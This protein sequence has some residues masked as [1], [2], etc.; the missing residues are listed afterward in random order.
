MLSIIRVVQP[1]PLVPGR[2]LPT[3]LPGDFDKPLEPRKLTH[4]KPTFRSKRIVTSV[5]KVKDDDK[6]GIY[7]DAYEKEMPQKRPVIVGRVA[8]G[9]HAEAAGVKQND[10][11]FSINGHELLT[12]KGS[13]ELFHR[14]VKGRPIEIVLLRPP[15]RKPFVTKHEHWIVAL[16]ALAVA[17]GSREDREHHWL[18]DG[19]ETRIP[20]IVFELLI[21]A[22][23]IGCC[24]L[25]YLRRFRAQTAKDIADFD[26]LVSEPPRPALPVR[27][28]A[29]GNRSPTSVVADGNNPERQKAA[30]NE[31]LLRSLLPKAES[32]H[33]R[34]HETT[35]N[36]AKLLAQLLEEK[37]GAEEA[38][39]AGRIRERFQVPCATETAAP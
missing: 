25:V 30:A 17:I 29:D 18:Q 36:T 20:P 8:E 5:V 28:K 6:M 13:I 33:G 23:V 34:F 24:L 38:D 2:S 7:L 11:I 4:G 15:P 14:A 22:C 9:M 27:S 3:M 37:G 19:V 16:I 31:V 12:P 35:K 26:G 39:E 32:D 10:V 1:T 21:L